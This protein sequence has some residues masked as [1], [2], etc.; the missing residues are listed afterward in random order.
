MMKIDKQKIKD[1]LKKI[2]FFIFNPHLLISL[3]IAWFITNGW[4]YLLLGLGTVFKSGWMLAVAGA[5]LTAL[6][7]PFTPEKIV[8]VF[9]AIG[10]LRLLFPE[11]KK[12]L[13]VLYEM[14]DLLKK[15]LTD[16]K[17]KRRQKKELRERSG[18]DSA[19]VDGK[20]AGGE[21]EDGAQNERVGKNGENNIANN[22]DQTL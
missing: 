17:E 12:T 11:D 19:S 18:K 4:S 21:S 2:L 5:Y 20:A 22:D 16:S 8:T 3:G 15:K 14:R 10:L 13:A 6:W 1:I 9:I 7:F